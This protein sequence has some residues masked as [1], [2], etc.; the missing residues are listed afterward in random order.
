MVENQHVQIWIDDGIVHGIYKKNCVVTHETAKEMVELRLQLQAGKLY[1]CIVYLLEGN[2]IYRPD[3][4]K[5]MAKQ[6]YEGMTKLAIITTS[7]AKTVIANIYIAIDKPVKPTRLFT[8]KESA[9][10]RLKQ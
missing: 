7:P 2:G 9:L 1:P 4:R 6:G 10:K 3:G 8:N 5:Y